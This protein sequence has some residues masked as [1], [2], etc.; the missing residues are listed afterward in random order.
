MIIDGRSRQGR[1][2]KGRE[3]EGGYYRIQDTIIKKNGGWFQMH[4]SFLSQHYYQ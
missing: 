1:D 4:L 3:Y 2:G